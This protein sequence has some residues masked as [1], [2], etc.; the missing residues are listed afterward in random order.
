MPGMIS[1]DGTIMAMPI[2]SEA[3]KEAMVQAIAGAMVSL[4]RGIIE[5]AVAKYLE[6]KDGTSGD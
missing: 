2:F 5:E 4:N 1:R 3:A 6:E